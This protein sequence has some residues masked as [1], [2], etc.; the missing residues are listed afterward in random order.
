MTENVSDFTKFL[1][2]HFYCNIYTFWRGGGL[3]LLT[4]FCQ[5]QNSLCV[6]VLCPPILAALLH[7]TRVVGVSQ[8]LRRW[9]DGATYIRQG[10][11]HVEHWPTFYC[12]ILRY[13]LYWREFYCCICSYFVNVSSYCVCV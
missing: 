1:N 8:T 10:D 13:F 5:L 7:G 9:A 3:L 11:H 4:E 12:S 2:W 6:Q